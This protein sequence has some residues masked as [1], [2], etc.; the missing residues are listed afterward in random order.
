MLEENEMKLLRKIAGEPKIDRIRSQQIREY[1][2]IQPII[3]Q[4]ERRTRRRRE[5]EQ[6]VTKMDAE[7]L[8]YQGTIY[9]PVE[10][11]QDALKEIEKLNTLLEHIE[12]P[13]TKK[14]KK[15]II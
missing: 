10:D 4:V 13:N 3:E 14:K 8:E 9:L 7:R 15:K 6:H 12:S 5:W 1:C 11:L 2:G